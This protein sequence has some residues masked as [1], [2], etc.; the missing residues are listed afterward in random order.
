MKIKIKV[1]MIWET[2]GYMIGDSKELIVRILPADSCL[3][4][5]NL[6]ML[7]QTLIGK[8]VSPEPRYTPSS[9]IP[10]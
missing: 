5:A 9:N 7:T 3:R 2:A 6:E 8:E 1:S 4:C 10:R